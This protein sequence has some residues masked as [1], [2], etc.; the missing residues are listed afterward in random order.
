MAG[1]TSTYLANKF[2]NYVFGGTSMSLTSTIYAALYTSMP[3]AGGGG[4]ECSGSGYARVAVTCN[5]TNFPAAS[6]QA[7]SNATVIDFGTPTGSGWGTVVGGGWYDSAT[8][9]NL[10]Y[11]G[12]F[13]PSR[14]AVAGLDFFVPIAG[15]IGTQS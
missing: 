11:A 6:G 13:T 12:P 9:G 3:T 4:T 8:G 5:T 1:F 15:F 2:L 14:S 10:L 7:I